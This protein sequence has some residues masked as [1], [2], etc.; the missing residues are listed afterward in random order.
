MATYY[1]DFDAA[2]GGNGLTT[3]TP[4]NNMNDAEST[5]T[6]N[7]TL[8]IKRGGVYNMNSAAN[9]RY[10]LSNVDNITFE[11][12]YNADGTDDVTQPKPTLE[13]YITSGTGDWTEV[14][15]ADPTVAVGT[16]GDSDLW[17]LSGGDLL[18]SPIRGVWFGT[19]KIPGQFRQQYWT[20]ATSTITD[21]TA[22]NAPS[23][24]YEFDWFKGTGSQANRLIVHSVGNPVTNF[25]AVYWAEESYDRVFDIFECDNITF[26]NIHF[27]HACV[28]MRVRNNTAS[29]TNTGPIVNN[30]DFE[31]CSI[32]VH[33]NTD[34]STKYISD[35]TI[36][37]CTFTD[38]GNSGVFLQYGAIEGSIEGCTFLRNGIA[39][40]AGGIYSR[41]HTYDTTIQ[42]YNNNFIDCKAG[43]YWPYDGG[44][45]ETDA[46][47]KNIEI[48]NNYFTKC[49]YA[50]KDNSGYSNTF[51]NNVV[52]DCGVL[53]HVTDSVPHNNSKPIVENNTALDLTIDNT[54][55]DDNT[56]TPKAAIDL[57]SGII[58]GTRVVNNICTGP[59]TDAG[60]LRYD[61][62]VA[63]LEENYNCFYN[64]TNAVIDESSN[65]ETAGTG[66][67]TSNPLIDDNGS[68]AST[69]PCLNAGTVP[70]SKY[71]AYSRPNYG[72]HI[73]AVWPRI[74]TSKIRRS[75]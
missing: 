1:V 62:D 15:A 39:D 69:S 55:N 18:Y 64:F 23:A 20:P 6:T 14:T 19:N 65:A 68:P 16:P 32:G 26:K 36:Q 53:T 44:G 63:D 57:P 75:V 35:W 49:M 56:Y 52:I 21:V 74:N 30:C 10:T 27:R 4:W 46:S 48:Y 47:T 8:K 41:Y 45:V 28:G 29:S 9:G 61:A 2:G 22:G 40:S 7:D 73:G 72:N 43:R 59:G 54:Y 34:S 58:A 24:N 71:D 17:I 51:R 13:F 3:S 33:I 38:I 67:I 60:V 66:T 11:T 70:L 25:G 5:V 42:I 37:N 50:W 12:Y 31:N